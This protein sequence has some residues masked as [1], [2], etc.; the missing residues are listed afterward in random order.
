MSQ[1][2]NDPGQGAAPVDDFMAGFNSD[3]DDDVARG[4]A[5]GNEQHGTGAGA[6]GA[7]AG[8]G[9][10]AAGA[11]SGDGD[12]FAAGM[13]GGDEGGGA[14][15]AAG[16]DG[17]GAQGV[18]TV[19]NGEQGRDQPEEI[20]LSGLP[21]NIRQ[22]LEQAEKDR[23][24]AE[25]LSGQLAASQRDYHAAVGRVAPLQSKLAALQ[26]SQQDAQAGAGT[27]DGQS[28]TE[29]S[30]TVAEAEQAIADAE[31]YFE[32]DDFKRYADMWPDEAK[33][34]R[35][36]Q[37][38]TLRAVRTLAVQTQQQV[39]SLNQTVQR[40]VVPHLEQVRHNEAV[41]AR[42]MELNELTEKHADWKQI[43]ASDEFGIWYSDIRPLLNF[44]D[45]EHERASVN[46]G[47][48]VADLITRFKKD[49]GWGSQQQ[50]QQD[51][52]AGGQQNN[53]A[54]GQERR[55]PNARLAMAGSPDARG[56][57]VVSRQGASGITPGDEFM[58]GFNSN[59]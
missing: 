54:G 36:T 11:G 53:A 46:D 43:N 9:T 3:G 13:A 29:V 59:D 10:G 38:R 41:T 2:N 23:E 44:R 19:E 7:G 33:M 8:A 21:E 14:G 12:Q 5:G 42:Q 22:R 35:E 16:D 39:G 56:G 58:A 27:G 17:Q 48:Y 49:T 50:Q 6:D 26:R 31:A 51:A 4:T 15:G 20:D 28:G 45:A 55:A 40:D 18:D 34:Q 1:S 37:M 25:A 30:G 57:A 32:S 47:K 24:R 52:G